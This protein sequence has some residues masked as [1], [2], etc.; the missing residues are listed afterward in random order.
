MS[1]PAC[2]RPRRT[3]NCIEQMAGGWH[4]VPDLCPACTR[5][6]MTA[7]DGIAGPLVWHQAYLDR[8]NR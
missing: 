5:A 7:L 6:F 4:G 2:S 8:A 3:G 1:R